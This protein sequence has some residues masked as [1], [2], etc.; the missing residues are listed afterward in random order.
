MLSLLIGVSAI[1]SGQAA[2]SPGHPA[3]PQVPSHANWYLP[4]APSWTL[5]TE[6]ACPPSTE[7]SIAKVAVIS[8]GD[9]RARRFT[10]SLVELRV[11]GRRADQQIFNS[12]AM[13]LARLGGLGAVHGSC[14]GPDPIFMVQGALD[15]TLR[16]LPFDLTRSPES[17]PSR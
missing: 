16:T 15:G 13:G 2:P 12:V 4:P 5:T 1:V 9:G 17:G 3:P 11:N 14:R 6:W 8:S 7:S 10:V